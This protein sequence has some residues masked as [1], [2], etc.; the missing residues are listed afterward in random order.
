MSN[1]H[2]EDDLTGEGFR[3]FVPAGTI[4]LSLLLMTLPLPLAWGLMP[5]FA[6]LFVIIWASIQ[7]RLIPAWAAFLLGLLADFLFGLPM[8]VWAVLFPAAVIA[9]RLAETRVEGHNLVVDWAFAAIL[10]IVAQLLA[11]QIMGFVG[12]APALL[13]MLAQAAISILAYPVVA[14]IA[15]RIQR[16]LIDVGI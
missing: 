16:R 13:P 11:W 15:A 10:L 3:R 2:F 9:V 7:P 8:G 5:Q 12:R 1:F 14:S 6:L 4:I